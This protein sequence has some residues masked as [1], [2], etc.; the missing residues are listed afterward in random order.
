MRGNVAVILL[1]SVFACGAGRKKKQQEAAAAEAAKAK[2]DPA[3]ETYLP[4]GLVRVVVDLNADNTP[5]LVR[6]MEDSPSGRILRKVESDMNK[7]GRPDVVSIFD[8]SGTLV[9]EEMDGDHDGRF[10]ITDT[11]KNGVLVL[12]EFDK[13]YDG[14]TDVWTHFAVGPEGKAIP[15]RV[16]RDTDGD[17]NVDYWEEVDANGNTVEWGRQGD[18]IELVPEQEAQ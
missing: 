7:D 10:D 17:G 8:P 3:S 4:N 14:R 18:G 13:D 9:R 16:E 15:R 2:N 1:V 5:Q 6:Y 11:Y 12:S